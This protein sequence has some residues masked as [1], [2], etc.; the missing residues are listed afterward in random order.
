MLTP[1][2]STNPRTEFPNDHACDR[3]MRILLNG[4]YTENKVNCVL[5]LALILSSINSSVL[6]SSSFCALELFS[7]VLHFLPENFFLGL[8]FHINFVKMTSR[9][10]ISA[11]AKNSDS[12]TIKTLLNNTASILEWRR[13]KAPRKVLGDSETHS[14]RFPLCLRKILKK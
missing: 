14:D 8:W 1:V 7:S 5:T 11:N 3:D 12:L 13:L 2:A 4:K 9:T 10:E 6:R